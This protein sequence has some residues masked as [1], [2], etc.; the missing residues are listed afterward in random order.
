MQKSLSFSISRSLPPGLSKH[1]NGVH[2]PLPKSYPDDLQYPVT[3][4]WLST[5]ATAK[6]G[7]NN[8]TVHSNLLLLVDMPP[9]II[10]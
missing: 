3:I 10:A 4:G 9:S 1:R 8:P 5:Y 2:S 6:I 7:E